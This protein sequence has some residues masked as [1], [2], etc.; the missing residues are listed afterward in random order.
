MFYGD[1][2]VLSRGLFLRQSWLMSEYQVFLAAG[3]TWGL[4]VLFALA[5]GAGLCLVAGYK[6][7]LASLFCWLFTVSLQLRNPVVLDGGD[8]ILRL[9]LFWCPF[10][11]LSARWSVESRTRPEW[12]EI[13]NT[14][15]SVATVGVTL[16]YV[17]LYFFAALLKTG[18]VWR[19]SGEALYY[20]LSID[21]FSTHLGKALLAYP[22][23]L[24][25][26]TP[27]V[28][29]L[30][31]SL[32]LLLLVPASWFW[33]RYLFLGLAFGF[34]L[35][36]ALTLHFGIFM[37]IVMAGLLAFVPG[38]LLD[39]WSSGGTAKVS[40]NRPPAYDLK[41][42]EAVLGAFILFYMLFV[43]IQSIEHGH[44]LPGWT[45]T[46]ARVTYQHQHWHL[47]AP[48]PFLEDGWFLLEVVDHKGQVWHSFAAQEVGLEK[49]A[50]VSTT[51]PNQ[52]WRRWFQNLVQQPFEDTQSWRNSTAHYL[53]RQWVKEHP[54]ETIKSYRLLF[55]EEM[56]PPP[57]EESSVEMK[58]LA[59]SQES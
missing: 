33:A 32:A 12:D 14:Y 55:M 9:L 4:S 44:R 30:E 19:K 57:G 54:G 37:F 21:Q 2:G 22:R 56:T 59:E 50:H 49:P 53:A 16:Q 17:L 8:E 51:F 29:V 26:M 13:S 6:T 41:S 18:E 46:V 42:W 35:G 23:L 7:R 38:H 43:N 39:R 28:L 52:R 27:S 58:V 15:R 36:I 40:E 24:E 48:R 10:L 1:E 3:S 20:T 11:P 31:F 25:L 47:F 5:A 45:Q 34:H